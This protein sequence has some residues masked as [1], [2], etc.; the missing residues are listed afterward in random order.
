VRGL[1]I[2]LIHWVDC[3][4]KFEDRKGNSYDFITLAPRYLHRQVK[5]IVAYKV[6]AESDK[7]AGVPNCTE[8]DVRRQANL[9][10]TAARL[11]EFQGLDLDDLSHAATLTW[12][13]KHRYT[14][15]MRAKPLAFTGTNSLYR[16][17]VVLIV[18]AQRATHWCLVVLEG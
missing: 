10:F 7:I 9:L 13:S 4:Y 5:A 6:N 17:A 8:E 3:H 14:P 15:K 12:E 2:N 11:P 16:V 18:Y 1:A